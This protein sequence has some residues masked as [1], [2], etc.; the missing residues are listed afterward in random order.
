MVTLLGSMIIGQEGTPVWHLFSS[1]VTAE[2]LVKCKYAFVVIFSSAVTLA[3]STVGILII[4]PSLRIIFA[5]L[6]ESIFLVVSLGMVSLRAGIK[7]A[8]FVEIPR[9]RMIKPVESIINFIICTVLACIIL[10]PLIPYAGTIMGLLNPL[11]QFYLYI[12]LTISGTIAA[13][14]TYSFY[15]IVVKNAKDFLAEAET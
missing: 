8:S 7:G 6:I 15:K 4:H 2:S 12:A 10:A 11:P 9:P 1:P 5:A 13:I 14:V 3:C